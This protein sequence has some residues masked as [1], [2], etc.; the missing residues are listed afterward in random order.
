LT[1]GDTLVGLPRTDG[2]RFG[3]EPSPARRDYIVHFAP[4][5]G[6][7]HKPFAD[8]DPVTVPPEP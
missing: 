1:L 3:P 8:A 5:P 2:G 7:P 4:A 6:N